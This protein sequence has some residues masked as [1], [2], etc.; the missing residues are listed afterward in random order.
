MGSYMKRRKQNTPK[1]NW[2]QKD[3]VKPE[4]YAVGLSFESAPMDMNSKALGDVELLEQILSVMNMGRAMEAIEKKKRKAPGVDGMRPG[5]L[6]K[7]LID[8]GNGRRIRQELLNG[9]YKPSPVQRVDIPKPGGGTRELG[10]P[11]VTSYYTTSNTL[12]GSARDGLLREM[13]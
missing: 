5:E 1:G 11:T 6:R 10:V 7:H 4:G 3:T 12:W 13:A 8:E 2:T 9:T